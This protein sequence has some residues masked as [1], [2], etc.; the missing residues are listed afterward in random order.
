[1]MNTKD[2]IKDRLEEIK[3]PER[4]DLVY[5][6][7]TKV[8]LHESM[9]NVTKKAMEGDKDFINRVIELFQASQDEQLLKL[10]GAVK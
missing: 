7:V 1:M 3:D 9:E 10:K 4:L 6:F 8:A 2:M 5:T